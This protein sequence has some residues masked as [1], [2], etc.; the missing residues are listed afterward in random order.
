MPFSRRSLLAAL[1]LALLAPLAACNKPPVS[2]NAVDITGANYGHA[3]SLPDADGRTR[4]LADFN[5]KI[6]VVFFGF[7]QCPDVCPS[8]LAE[9]AQ[10]KKNLGADGDKV[11]GVFITIDPARDTPEVLKGYVTSFD[12]GFVALRGSPEQTASTAKDFKVY[13]AKVPGKTEGSYS[14]DHTAGS[15]VFDGKGRV[16]LFTRH[17][18][19][20]DALTSDLKQLIKAGA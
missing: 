17:G 9:L 5:G 1:G 16:R 15:Y 8:T 18:S 4:T 2:Y 7:T 19:G 13:Y 20:V 6:V 11:Q 10:A 14:M 12:P 3:L